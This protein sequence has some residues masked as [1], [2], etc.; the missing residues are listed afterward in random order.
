M[1]SGRLLVAIAIPVFSTQLERLREATD[2]A[3]IRSAY[4]EVMVA[5]L[6]N[7]DL[8]KTIE[9]NILITKRTS[10][11]SRACK[12][13]QIL[14]VLFVLWDRLAV[15]GLYIEYMIHADSPFICT[16]YNMIS[17]FLKKNT[18]QLLS[19]S[20]RSANS[21][22]NIRIAVSLSAIVEFIFAIVAS[23]SAIVASLSANKVTYLSSASV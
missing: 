2:L 16:W 20:F 17:V 7:E 13:A 5:A 1:L 22:S 15:P 3:N 12:N 23:L 4:A 18:N 21:F 8:K 10:R 14:D 9:N 6:N 19:L 11:T